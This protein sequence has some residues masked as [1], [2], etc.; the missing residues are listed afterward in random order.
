MGKNFILKSDFCKSTVSNKYK[1]NLRREESNPMLSY[2]GI[3]KPPK[4]VVND[5]LLF[6][7]KLKA[8]LMIFKNYLIKEKIILIKL[9]KKLL[10]VLML[11]M[12]KQLNILMLMKIMMIMILKM[13]SIK[14]ILLGIICFKII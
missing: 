10:L 7:K 8:K 9:K 14:M 5:Y 12:K 1:N 2:Y 3:D 6:V 4:N 13:N 11:M